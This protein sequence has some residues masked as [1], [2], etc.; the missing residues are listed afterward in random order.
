MS[1]LD[2]PLIEIRANVADTIRELIRRRYDRR[3]VLAAA[4]GA[5]ALGAFGGCAPRDGARA[6]SFERIAPGYSDDVRVPAAYVADVVLRWGDAIIPGAAALDPAA[7][8]RGALLAPGAA[9]AQARQFGYNCDGMGL[10]PVAS[11]RLVVCVNHE[12]PSPRIMF[13]GWAEAT[14][15]R[16]LEAYVT[17]R[18]ES[19]RVMQASVGL[20]VV[21]LVHDG[22][23]RLDASSRLNR[24]VTAVTPLV[25]SGPAST[26]AL[27]GGT[28]AAPAAGLGTFGNCAAGT[29]PW[30]TYLT[31]EE[32]VDDFFGNGQNASFS[33]AATRGHRRFGA[34]M[35]QSAYRW[36]LV[37]PR[38]D[39]ALNPDEL[40]K[41]GWI[42]ELDPFDADEPIRK[43][44]ALGRFK[45]EAATTTLTRDGRAAIYMGDDQIFEYFY[46]F[47]SSRRP[48][49]LGEDA[50]RTLLDE[51]T[52]YVARL[53]AD[54]SGRW[55]PLEWSAEGPLSP[56][57]GFASQADVLLHCRSAADLLGA[58]PLDRPE[59]AAI[60]PLSG[61]IYL[62]CTQ[63]DSRGEPPPDAVAQRGIAT[64]TDAANPRH[65]N[66]A[67]HIIE[68]AERDAD[69]AALEFQWDLLI[70]AGEPTPA[71]LKTH[72]AAPMAGEDVYF[73]G[74]D[75][76]SLLSGFANP[77]NLTCDDRGNLWIVTDG[78]QPEGRNNGC[79][80]CPT[81]GPL[82]GAVRQ[83]MSGPVGAEICGCELTPDQQTL[84][85]TV[86]HPGGS[87]TV[88]QP[89]SRWPD[90]GDAAPRPSLI[91]IEPRQRGTR[92]GDV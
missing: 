28:P 11:D 25:F 78:D 50:K 72:P 18:S 38:F 16:E 87:G 40:F 19:V 45:H 86:Q 61:R 9:D 88:E 44:T 10:F 60:D 80:V 55:L 59:D 63:N 31:A 23:W 49:D 70:V 74:I 21:E 62:A 64:A 6:S 79:F 12:F 22:R 75:D 53:D 30:G 84:F 65:V 77:D 71:A 33:E 36:E 7:V 58:T 20:S 1:D 56:R 46:K 48:A 82:R 43:R 90:G 26:H 4:G 37:D 66:H 15:A 69:A 17:A 41:F 2:G 34:R 52:L 91:A 47:V 14:A 8:A 83:F 51:G 13:P 76:V 42:V 3:S 57:A 24:R 73:G 92:I 39:L 27:L 81:S 32:N 67:G 89:T 68:F 85:L 35:R 54:G 5:I 29:T